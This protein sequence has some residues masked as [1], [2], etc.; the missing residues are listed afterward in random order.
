MKF[1]DRVRHKGVKALYVENYMGDNRMSIILLD[2]G[3]NRRIVVTNKLTVG[4]EE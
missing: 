3:L 2:N 1:G 4:W